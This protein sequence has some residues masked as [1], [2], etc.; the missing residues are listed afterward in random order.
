MNTKLKRIQNWPGLAKEAGWSVTRLAKLC[1][2]SSATLR[3]HFLL[4]T[5]KSSRQW[6]AE[7]RQ[8]QALALL[9]DGCS[10]KEIA[11]YLDYKQQTNFTR[12]FKEHWGVCPTVA[13]KVQVF[14][15]FA[16]K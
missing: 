6:L 10:I 7:E 12:K 2:V 16:R 1:A 3:R 9:Q 11:N 8:R 4:I 5:T 13:R 14:R 15:N